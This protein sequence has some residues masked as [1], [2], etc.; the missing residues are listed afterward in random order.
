MSGFG[1]SWRGCGFML[2]SCAHTGCGLRVQ[3]TTNGN[4]LKNH[5]TLA[6]RIGALDWPSAVA[7]LN[8]RGNAVLPQLLD[9]ADCASM[10][11]L[12]GDAARFRSRVVMQRHG[13]GLGEYQYFAYPLPEAVASLR[14]ALYPQ[15]A[16]LANAWHG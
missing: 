7:S 6:A 15:L 13:F 10:A 5:D 4:P 3:S 8:A 1:A 11:R 9:A 2:A 14:T 16:G 12:Y